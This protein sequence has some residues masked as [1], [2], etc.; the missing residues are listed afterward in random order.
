M[1]ARAGHFL[2]AAAAAVTGF[3]VSCAER[4]GFAGKRIHVRS[5]SLPVHSSFVHTLSF[6][7]SPE[8]QT[9]IQPVLTQ[10]VFLVLRLSQWFG[11]S[12]FSCSRKSRAGPAQVLA[13]C[14]YHFL[15]TQTLTSLRPCKF[16]SCSCCPPPPKFDKLWT[17]FNRVVG[18]WKFLEYQPFK[19][20][21]LI[22][23]LKCQLCLLLIEDSGAISPRREGPLTCV[24]CPKE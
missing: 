20:C 12:Q 3:P 6:W 17:S 7:N 15:W 4:K 16:N 2:R 11:F 9:Q 1:T 22:C 21:N 10:T 23:R 24:L 8:S 5:Y 18:L 14:L 13:P 19:I